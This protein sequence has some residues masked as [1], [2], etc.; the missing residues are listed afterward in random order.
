MFED[1][2]KLSAADIAAVAVEIIEKTLTAQK[3]TSTQSLVF[4]LKKYPEDKAVAWAEKHDFKY[5]KV[6]L[7][8]SGD[9][10]RLRQFDPDECQEGS[11]RNIELTDGIQAVICRRKE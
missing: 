2:T 10:V 4:D 11:F 8:K 7:P 1:I 3:S 9:S 5:G 6:D